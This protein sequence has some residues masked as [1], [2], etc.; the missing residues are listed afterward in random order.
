MSIYVAQPSMPDLDEFIE[1]IRPVWE[2]RILS[3]MGPLHDKFQ[4]LLAGY[5]SVSHL[6]LF[7][8][9]HAALELAIEA[10]GL[11]GEVIT[12]PYT[13]A[14]TTHA[15]VRRGLTPVFCDIKPDD[16][17]IDPA[18][19]EALITEKTSAIIPV[20]VYG[21]LCDVEVIEAVARKYGLKVL[22]DSA[23][24]FGVRYKGRGVGSFGDAAMFSFHATKVF[25]SIEGGA[26]AF[27]DAC[28]KQ[29]LHLLRNFG[30]AGEEQIESVGMNAKLDE[31][32]SAMGICNLRHL[33]GEMEKRKAVFE[34]YRGHLAGIPGLRLNPVQQDVEPNYAYF[35]LYVDPELFG[36]NRDDLHRFLAQHDIFVRKYFYPAVNHFPCYRGMF[37][38]GNTPVS[39]RVSQHILTLPM[40]AGLPLEEVDRICRVVLSAGS[41][42]RPRV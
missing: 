37:P 29:K 32:R 18:R 20:H 15:I 22:Y 40:Y 4:K 27:R 2:S 19:I 5:L 41:L 16:Y 24:A 1:E 23:Q 25:H 13:F 9:G 26:L 28:L 12:T 11:T 33:A 38:R 10:L 17:T 42:K 21:N 8:N 36:C 7:V 3:N 39:D 34:R 31:F 6:S 14:S 30:I 35:P